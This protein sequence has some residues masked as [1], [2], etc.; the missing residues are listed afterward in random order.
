MTNFSSSKSDLNLKYRLGLEHALARADFLNVPNITL[1]QAFAIFL[2][3]VRR[4]DSPRFV[5]MMTG[6]VIRM[7][8]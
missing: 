4:H 7:A 3:L 5:W 2:G 8:Q 1:V 6:L